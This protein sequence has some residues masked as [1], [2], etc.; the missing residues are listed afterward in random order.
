LAPVDFIFIF[1]FIF[2]FL[3]LWQILA[4]HGVKKTQKTG[5]ICHKWLVLFSKKIVRIFFGFCGNVITFQSAFLASGAVFFRL[6]C[7]WEKIL[8]SFL[9]TFANTCLGFYIGMLVVYYYFQKLKKRHCLALGFYFLISMF[10]HYTFL[11]KLP[12]E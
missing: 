12:V 1:I 4:P 11:R 10:E 5:I 8:G 9:K 3:F 7:C 6:C 2:Y